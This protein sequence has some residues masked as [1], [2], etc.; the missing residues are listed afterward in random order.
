MNKDKYVLSLKLEK[1]C[2]ANKEMEFQTLCKQFLKRYR[3][4]KIL[5]TAGD[6]TINEPY[7]LCKISIRSQEHCLHVAYR[8]N[9]FRRSTVYF[10]KDAIY[11]ALVFVTLLETGAYMLMKG[12]I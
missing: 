7:N 1:A 6:K 9:F 5:K 2:W 4:S 12:K 11:S 10:T 3:I 8:F